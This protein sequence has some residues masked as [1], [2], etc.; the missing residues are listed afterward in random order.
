MERGNERTT[1]ERPTL[2]Q[3]AAV[4][5][6]THIPLLPPLYKL[7]LPSL[8]PSLPPLSSPLAQV[9]PAAERTD[10]LRAYTYTLSQLPSRDS[11]RKSC[12]TRPEVSL[13]L[14]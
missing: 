9:P 13:T 6:L 11:P 5:A 12:C 1:I 3:A 10:L 2:P 8:P 4:A 7:S 14:L